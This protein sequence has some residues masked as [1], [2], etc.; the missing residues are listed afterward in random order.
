[1]IWMNRRSI[2]LGGGQLQLINKSKA[3]EKQ[4]KHQLMNTIRIIFTLTIILT[5]GLYSFTNSSTQKRSSELDNIVMVET[6]MKTVSKEDQIKFIKEK[7]DSINNGLKSYRYQVKESEEES[8]SSRTTFTLAL[9]GD[10]ICYA[11]KYKRTDNGREETSYYFSDNQL[12]F[13]LNKIKKNDESDNGF[14][15]T[16]NE[17]YYLDETEILCIQRTNKGKGDFYTYLQFLKDIPN[18][19]LKCNAVFDRTSI[20][21]I[22]EYNYPETKAELAVFIKGEETWYPYFMA[23]FH[24]SDRNEI[25]NININIEESMLYDSFD[26]L[27]GKT[28]MVHYEEIITNKIQKWGKPK[29]EADR[30][31]INPEWEVITG[32]LSGA[33]YIANGDTP[34]ELDITNEERS[35]FTFECWVDSDMMEINNTIVTVYYIPRKD[36]KITGF[37]LVEYNT[38]KKDNSQT[39]KHEDQHITNQTLE[40][41]QGTWQH[42]D[43]SSNYLVFEGNLRKETANGITEWDDEEFTLS[44][45]CLNKSEIENGLAKEESQYM[46]CK[47]SDLCWYIIK[48]DEDTLKLSYV[49]R[50]NTLTYMRVSSGQ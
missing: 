18:D 2:L 21:D 15:V 8:G 41:L 9:E 44:D 34:D 31:A 39:I 5:F 43:D 25:E 29:N 17:T 46:S 50:G 49:G 32:T 28:V 22:L 40:L 35:D 30:E 33:E 16:E 11:F 14:K 37:H 4:P 7:Y 24:F 26:S 36:K 38:S 13:K 23:T 20:K 19:T 42:I 1:M 6:P 12:I 48:L 47:N 10:K 27:I 3:I 45:A